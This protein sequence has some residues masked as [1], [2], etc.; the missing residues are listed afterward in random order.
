LAFGFGVAIS[1]NK[2]TV[3]SGCKRTKKVICRYQTRVNR[4]LKAFDFD[5]FGYW[6]FCVKELKIQ[7]SEAWG[8]DFVEIKYLADLDEANKQDLS[9]MLNYE[10]KRNGA[11]NEFLGM[12]QG[13]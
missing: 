1:R 13:A 10:R 6:K 8:L 9:L 3:Y 5:H 12:N 2:Q 7:P 11:T 4:K